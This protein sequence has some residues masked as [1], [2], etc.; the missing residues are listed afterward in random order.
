MHDWPYFL[1]SGKAILFSDRMRGESWDDARIEVLNLLT[2]E[3][4]P[5]IQG[6]T[7]PRL[8]GS[9]HL[10]YARGGS[11]FAVPFDSEKLVVTGSPISMVEGVH[12]NAGTGFAAY[13][14]SRFG[15]LAYVSSVA[16]AKTARWFGSTE[17]E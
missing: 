9:S 5:L 14:F 15:D 11:L 8:A 17:K 1:P 16:D 13:S 10:V 4:R 7:V 2:G 3:R 12:S 6:G